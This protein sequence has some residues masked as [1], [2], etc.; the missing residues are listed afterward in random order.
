VHA[1]LQTL[2]GGWA[3]V[4]QTKARWVEE[5]SRYD[6]GW[7][8]IGSPL[9]WA[10][11]DDRGAIPNRL[12]TYLLAGLPVITDRRP[13]SYRYDELRRRGV[14]VELAEGDHDALRA[15]LEEEVR[16][17]TRSL[18]ARSEREAYSFDA[19]IDSLL[20]VLERARG[21]YLAK[22]HDERTRFQPNSRQRLVHFNT[23][24]H[25]STVAKGLVQRPAPD[26]G[27]A[28][29]WRRL[30]LPLRTWQVRRSLRAWVEQGVGLG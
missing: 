27:L 20:G 12:G 22:P 17:R 13:G 1:S 29:Q 8:Y 5:F 19:S 16:T 3:D 21:C 25:R 26:S 4:Q 15:Q 9:P 6:A 14:E 23:S 30:L 11:L 2:G 18:R 7:S 24:P 28:G 10:L